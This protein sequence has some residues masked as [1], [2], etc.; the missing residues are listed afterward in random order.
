VLPAARADAFPANPGFEQE[1]SG[2]TALAE[3]DVSWPQGK[4]A[5][6]ARCLRLSDGWVVSDVASPDDAVTGWQ[7]MT[8]VAQRDPAHPAEAGLAV[9]FVADAD[10]QPE[11][12][13]VLQPESLSAPRWHRIEAEV[14]APGWE[15]LRLAFGSLGEGAWLIDQVSL[16][17]FEPPAYEAADDAPKLPEPLPD[18]WEPEGL[19][20]AR[21]RILG[22]ERELLVQV[23]GIEIGTAD[24]GQVSRAH[25]GG[26][27]IYAHNRGQVNKE[28]TIAV[29]APPGFFVP[30]RTVPIRGRGTTVID[31]SVQCLIVGRHSLRVE[32]RSG[33]EV[34]AAPLVVECEPSYP[35]FG[36]A[37]PSAAPLTPEQFQAAMT[38]PVQLHQ[39]PV[40]SLGKGAGMLALIP[41]ETE[42]AALI[43]QPWSAEACEQAVAE[44]GRRA[45]FF[46]LHRLRSAPQPDLAPELTA[47][48]TQ[49]LKGAGLDAKVLTPPLEP[50][51]EQR[52]SF[53]GVQA[54]PM[55]RLPPLK[56][57]TVAGLR[58]DG[59][60]SQEPLSCWTDLADRFES[61]VNELLGAREESVAFAISELGARPSGSPELDALVLARVMLAAAR[62]SAAFLTVAARPEDCPPGAEAFALLTA[63]G[64]LRPIVAQ[65]FAELTRELAGALPSVVLKATEQ[66]SPHPRA[67]I[68]MQPFLRGS[69]AVLALCNNTGAEVKLAIEVRCL[70]LDLHLLEIGVGGVRRHYTGLFRFSED[71]RRL[72]RPT[73]F[74]TLQPAQVQVLSMHLSDAHTAWLAGVELKPPIPREEKPRE[75]PFFG[76]RPW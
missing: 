45:A 72:G 5:A 34:K 71:A 27:R 35:A 17:P 38:L 50:D 61:S 39:V 9:A 63:D 53:A 3:A 68:V 59:R 15:G 25:R 52:A 10:A 70:P 51:L 1:A 31:T 66:I 20:D 69:E 30:E 32:F 49:A 67:A 21:A 8:F 40:S 62:Q 16:E 42:L 64:Q 46:G 24:R 6:G 7:R 36:A 58:V 41:Q 33:D 73:I 48:L 18:G 60:P 47:A 37:W 4:G 43:H 75:S 26:L 2:W 29:Q 28:L 19:L 14:F 56:V 76:D 54:I 12:Q 44:V 13:L 57:P 74:V 55:L 11:A 65:T 23:N 22:T